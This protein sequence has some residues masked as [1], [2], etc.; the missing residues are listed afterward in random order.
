[1]SSSSKELFPWKHRLAV[2]FGLTFA[3]NQVVFHLATELARTSEL[4]GFEGP[5]E[6]AFEGKVILN[7][8]LA[9]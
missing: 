8:N 5:P 7:A 2:S 9:Y 4:V 1:M 6:T 3:V